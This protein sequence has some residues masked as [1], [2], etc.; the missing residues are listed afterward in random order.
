MAGA[1]DNQK[2]NIINNLKNVYSGVGNVPTIY[3]N[4]DV[5]TPEKI[6]QVTQIDNWMEGIAKL[7]LQAGLFP[8]KT[9]HLHIYRINNN[10]DLLNKV[11]TATQ[12]LNITLTI[13]Q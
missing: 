1:L 4:V 7:I 12:G 6:I 3:E 13:E 10:N 2:I 8:T 11:I 9:K 5:L